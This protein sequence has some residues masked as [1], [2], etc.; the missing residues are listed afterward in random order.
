MGG[1]RFML[2]EM[3]KASFGVYVGDSSRFGAGR[4]EQQR[5]HVGAAAVTGAQ[6]QTLM[7]SHVWTA[8]E[9][10]MFKCNV[11]AAIFKDRNCYGAGMCI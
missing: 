11:D 1:G 5:H 8:S 9:Q 2:A 4:R 7:N 6:Q 10:G 3:A